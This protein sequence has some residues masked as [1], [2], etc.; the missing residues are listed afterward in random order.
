MPHPSAAELCIQQLAYTRLIE[1][2]SQFPAAACS[3]PGRA[4]C[5][6]AQAARGPTA[7]AVYSDHSWLHA[8]GFVPD[9]NL[10]GENHASNTTLPFCA[11]MLHTAKCH[12][13]S[14]CVDLQSTHKIKE[15]YQAQ[16]AKHATHSSNCHAGDC[17]SRQDCRQKDAL[18]TFPE[19]N[20]KAEIVGI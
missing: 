6:H 17:T 11:E 9:S 18:S 4:C 2:N 19:R 1:T 3:R 5:S 14:N 16:R 15:T 13:C 7:H 20:H 12:C 8:N 10:C